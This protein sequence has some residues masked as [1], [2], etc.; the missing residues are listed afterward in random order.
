MI[1]GTVADGDT[2]SNIDWSPITAEQ[3]SKPSG[4]MFLLENIFTKVAERWA[5]VPHFQ[6]D[7][8]V[9]DFIEDLLRVKNYKYF[10]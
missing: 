5:K 7:V 2:T 1:Q 3:L 4:K 6:S 10:S 9:L 8:F